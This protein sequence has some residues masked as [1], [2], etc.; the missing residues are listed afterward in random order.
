MSVCV[1][2]LPMISAKLK[3]FFRVF[4]ILKN[5]EKIHAFKG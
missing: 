3:K 1:C 4:S 2:A 5:D